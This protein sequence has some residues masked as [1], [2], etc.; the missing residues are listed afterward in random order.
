LRELKKISASSTV[1]IP[2]QPQ[3]QSSTAQ[4]YLKEILKIE[5]REL[6]EIF[7][8]QKDA[9]TDD[10]KN[11]VNQTLKNQVEEI[12]QNLNLLQRRAEHSQE[13]KAKLH[14]AVTSTDSDTDE[15]DDSLEN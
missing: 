13:R 8:Q 15:N 4:V 14:G 11:E 6:S 5:R 7:D 10:D 3:V 1:S 2:D 9:Q 12:D